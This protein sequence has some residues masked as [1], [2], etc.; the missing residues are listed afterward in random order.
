[1]KNKIIWTLLAV[2]LIVSSCD[3]NEWPVSNIKLVPIF[4]VTSVVGVTGNPTGTVA[5][6]ALEIYKEKAL[7]IEYTTASL[8]SPLTTSAYVDG[9]TDSSYNLNF[10]A[11]ILSKTALKQDTILNRRYELIADKV[12]NSGTL[13]VVK[14][15]NQ[16]SVV[17]NFTIKVMEDSV[18]N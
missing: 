7:L 13:K 6:Y 17:T 8:M 5:P 15:N 1:M 11:S 9:S 2:V 3:T 12:T 4:K 16:D 10:K 18:Y 14:Y